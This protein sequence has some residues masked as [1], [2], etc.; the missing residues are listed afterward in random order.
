[1]AKL[2][3]SVLVV[4]LDYAEDATERRRVL[5]VEKED[6]EELRQKYKVLK[7]TPAAA[8]GMFVQYGDLLSRT[9]LPDSFG[10]V[11]DTDCINQR[12]TMAYQQTAAQS[13]VDSPMPARILAKNA[14]LTV[15]NTSVYDFCL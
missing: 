14:E 3:L 7:R 9:S 11:Q 13:P 8:T 15:Q 10:H 6:T 4:Q 5:E 2:F 12:W 1:M